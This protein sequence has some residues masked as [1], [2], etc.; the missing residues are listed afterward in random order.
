MLLDELE[1]SDAPNALDV[2]AVVAAAQD[3]QVCELVLCQL[4]GGGWEYVWQ[5]VEEG[6]VQ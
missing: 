2:G 6:Q 4:W 3:A 5:V 1:G